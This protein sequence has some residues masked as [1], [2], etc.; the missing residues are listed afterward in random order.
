MSSNLQGRSDEFLELIAAQIPFARYMGFE[1]SSNGTVIEFVMPYQHKLIGNP[2]LPA[3]HGGGVAGFLE[4]CA[5]VTLAWQNIERLISNSD[6]TIDKIIGKG[7]LDLPRTIDFSIDYLRPGRPEDSFARAQINRLGRRYS[8]VN[9]EAW[10][11]DQSRLFA[12]ATG[13]FMMPSTF[14]TNR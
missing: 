8:S 11:D 4:F 2:L 14:E 9:V 3:L 5:I 12:Q 7:R 13:H 10:Q 6:I 1:Y